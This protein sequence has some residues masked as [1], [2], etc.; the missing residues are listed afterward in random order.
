MPLPRCFTLLLTLL[1]LRCLRIIFA[2]RRF[3]LLLLRYV[4]YAIVL[5]C[6]SLHAIHMPRHA[7]FALFFLMLDFAAADTLTLLGML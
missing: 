6:C 7:V 4:I 2:C 5:P 1:P 3:S